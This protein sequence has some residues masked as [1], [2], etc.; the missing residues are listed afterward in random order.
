[1]DALGID[2]TLRVSFAMYNSPDDIDRFVEAL[3]KA[4]SML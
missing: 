3:D 2:G 4:C 1:M